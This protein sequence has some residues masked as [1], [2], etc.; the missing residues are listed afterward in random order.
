MWTTWPSPVAKDTF[1]IRTASGYDVGRV[2]VGG[3]IQIHK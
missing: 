1:R 2:L 3:D